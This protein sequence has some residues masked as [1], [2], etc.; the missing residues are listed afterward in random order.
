M[1]WYADE[2][3]TMHGSEERSVEAFGVYI[4]VGVDDLH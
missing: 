4:G 3:L 2:R 1:F